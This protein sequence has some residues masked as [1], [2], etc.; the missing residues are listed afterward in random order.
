MSF[1]V[2]YS[3]DHCPYSLRAR[4]T[5]I[6][7]NIKCELREVMLSQKPQHLLEV[8]PKGTVPVLLLEDGSVLE[9]SLDIMHWALDNNDPEEW[10]PS[11]YSSKIDALIQKND[12]ELAPALKRYREKEDEDAKVLEKKFWEDSF[13]FFEEA[14][15]GNIFLI[16]PKLSIADVAIFPFVRLASKIDPLWFQEMPFPHLKRW[17]LSFTKLSL[18]LKSMAKYKPWKEGES[19][20]FI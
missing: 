10:R 11:G 17:L 18:F 9:Q 19:P 4:I 15:K 3:N 12:R 20:L 16:G 5:L 7:A 6:Y 13:H 14:L 2:L 1:P 8:S